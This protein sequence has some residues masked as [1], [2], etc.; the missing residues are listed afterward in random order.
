M[1]LPPGRWVAVEVEE[2]V[3]ELLPPL[4]HVVNVT[5]VPALTLALA[6]LGK[7]IT[8][9][10]LMKPTNPSAQRDATVHALLAAT[11]QTSGL[12]VMFPH[13]PALAQKII[14]GLYTAESI[15]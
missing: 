12:G 15:H 13:T 1:A 8:T 14:V 9:G 4:T 6:P 10:L 3:E 5:I 11:Q 7:I 2:V